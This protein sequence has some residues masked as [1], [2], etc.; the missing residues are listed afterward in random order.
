MTDQQA[1]A[2]HQQYPHMSAETFAYY[3]GRN[4]ERNDF[5]SPALVKAYL[6]GRR[7]VQAEDRLS[8]DTEWDAD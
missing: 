5:T 6:R 8:A 3:A 2:R 1:Q 4:G 7:E